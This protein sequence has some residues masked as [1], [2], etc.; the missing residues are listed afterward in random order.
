[1]ENV[2]ISSRWRENFPHFLRFFSSPLVCCFVVSCIVRKF[3]ALSLRS[4]SEN[5]NIWK[6]CS[7]VKFRR[8]K[9]MK[10]V[11]KQRDFSSIAQV[12]RS[13]AEQSPRALMRVSHIVISKSRNLTSFRTTRKIPSLGKSAFTLTKLSGKLRFSWKLKKYST[14]S[15][16]YS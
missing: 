2:C 7:V 3:P 16:F 13:A 12:C 1:M 11:C 15:G 8:E 5:V 4:N 9:I 10:I 6:S 14:Y